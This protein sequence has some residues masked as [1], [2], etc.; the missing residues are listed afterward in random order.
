LFLAITFHVVKRATT[1][2]VSACV[3]TWR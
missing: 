1:I 2:M 3:Y